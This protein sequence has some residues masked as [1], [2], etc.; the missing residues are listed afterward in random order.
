MGPERLPDVRQGSAG[1]PREIRIIEG[2]QAD[3][4]PEAAGVL[5]GIASTKL[6]WLTGYVPVDLL[7]NFVAACKENS[8]AYASADPADD[9][10]VPTKLKNN[11]L[12][13]I[14]KLNNM[15][16]KLLKINKIYNNILRMLMR[17]LIKV[18]LLMKVT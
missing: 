4:A 3:E 18:V 5:E 8:W 6:A 2:S 16:K 17:Q 14:K 13:L 15:N 1:F 10:P 7:P 11:K 9:D 12:L